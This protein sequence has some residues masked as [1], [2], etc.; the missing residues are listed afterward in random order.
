MFVLFLLWSMHE[1]TTIAWLNVKYTNNCAF[2]RWEWYGQETNGFASVIEWIEM[3]ID[4]I[5]LC[6]TWILE[7]NIM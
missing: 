3:N 5:F 7:F 6:K 4:H 2:K 1:Y